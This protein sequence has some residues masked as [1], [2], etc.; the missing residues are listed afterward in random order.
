M[1]KKYLFKLISNP[2]FIQTL[3]SEAPP[4]YCCGNPL[5]DGCGIFVEY[6]LMPFLVGVALVHSHVLP[7][8]SVQK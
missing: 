7:A 6:F 8:G 1:L 2:N 4:N 3:L 5:D